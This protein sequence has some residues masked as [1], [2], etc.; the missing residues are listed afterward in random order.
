MSMH[1]CWLGYQP[2]EAAQGQDVLSRVAGNGASAVLRTA[3]AELASGLAALTASV[4]A[5]VPEQSAEPHVL[6]AAPGSA[7]A[8]QARAALGRPADGEQD[9]DEIILI[10]AQA[11]P[12]PRIII[13]SNTEARCCM[14]SSPSSAGCSSVRPGNL[15][16]MQVAEAAANR[17]RMVSHWDNLDGTVE[18]GY[19]GA[20]VFFAGAR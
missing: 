15:T 10:C 18:R 7:R 16:E 5:V 20:S 11:R 17:L 8:A 19:A 9:A 13:T 12:L 2:A 3:I 6:V 4:P 14:P 1:D